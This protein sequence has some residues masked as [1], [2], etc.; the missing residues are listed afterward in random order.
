MKGIMKGIHQLTP[1][2]IRIL[3]RKGRWDKP[4]AGLAMGYAQR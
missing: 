1:E 3:I 4:T 2:E